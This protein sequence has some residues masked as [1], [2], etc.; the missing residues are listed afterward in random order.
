M[1]TAFVD[2]LLTVGG[3]M[4]YL[5][6]G[7]LVFAEAALFIGFVLPGETAVLLGGV[8]AST[9]HVSL[10][11]LLAVVVIGA[12]AG[13]SVGYEVGH[14]FGP[15]ILKLRLLQRHQTRLSSAQQLLRERGGWA[16]LM[17]RFIAFLRAVMPAL[18]GISGM[19]YR[20]FLLFNALGGLV[21]GVGITL[22]GFLAGH[23][24][25][26][27]EGTLGRTSAVLILAFVVIAVFLW[28]RQRR[29]TTITASTT[30]PATDT[31]AEDS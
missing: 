16:V 1:M 12:V 26:A 17:G 30:P 14:H 8:L 7:L 27:V 10:P 25:K 13:D 28:R 29:S 9:G 15:R 23:S 24:Y 18:A 5:I 19:P 11:I 22:I 21:W 20:R 4:A 6:V 31:R 2:S 3:P